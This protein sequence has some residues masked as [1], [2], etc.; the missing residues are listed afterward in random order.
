MA[1]R[2]GKGGAARN[3]FRLDYDILFVFEVFM[4]VWVLGMQ[5]GGWEMAVGLDRPPAKWGAIPAGLPCRKTGIG[6]DPEWLQSLF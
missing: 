2:L 5:F 6:V 3:Q 4:G 1:A